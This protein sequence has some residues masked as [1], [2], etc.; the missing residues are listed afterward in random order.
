MQH[1]QA[2]VYIVR[3]LVK[4]GQ[5]MYHVNTADIACMYADGKLSFALDFSGKRHPMAESLSVLE[6]QLPEKDFYKVSRHLVVNIKSVRCIHPWFS[7]RLKLELQPAPEVDL[8]VSRE[9][10]AG[11]KEWLGK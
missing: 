11:F 3:F 4:T 2:P 7:G 8:E 6:T 10:V 9:R 1:L 5:Q